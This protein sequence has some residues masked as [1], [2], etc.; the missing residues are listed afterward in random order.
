ML[1][2]EPKIHCIYLTKNSSAGLTTT[3]HDS[4]TASAPTSS[5]SSTSTI[6]PPSYQASTST[7]VGYSAPVHSYLEHGTIPLQTGCSTT[8][9]TCVESDLMIKA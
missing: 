5:D 1:V 8:L 4:A 7:S 2:L 3:A 9:V 6:R